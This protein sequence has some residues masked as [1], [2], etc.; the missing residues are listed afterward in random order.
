[1]NNGSKLWTL[2]KL[3]LFFPLSELY[4]WIAVPVENNILSTE[5]PESVDEYRGRFFAW[6]EV[7]D[8]RL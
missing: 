6:L 2:G 4:E 1:M 5:Q 3:A 7:I 8:V